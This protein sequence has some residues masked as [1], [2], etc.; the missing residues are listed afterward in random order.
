MRQ[1]ELV[2]YSGVFARIHSGIILVNRQI[3][4]TTLVGIAKED[5]SVFFGHLQSVSEGMRRFSVVD[6]H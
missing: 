1:K 2:F 5:I 4:L 6:R 3:L